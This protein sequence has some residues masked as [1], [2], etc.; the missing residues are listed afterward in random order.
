MLLKYGKRQCLT[1]IFLLRMEFSL[2][3]DTKE[4][5]KCPHKLRELTSDTPSA[6][7]AEHTGNWLSIVMPTVLSNYSPGTSP[8][9]AFPLLLVLALNSTET[10]IQNDATCETF[11]L[12][13][14]SHY[15]WLS[16]PVSMNRHTH[17]MAHPVSFPLSMFI[18]F[19][20]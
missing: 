4:A 5:A 11:P 3:E 2:T 19:P 20:L 8:H 15:P 6:L 13:K 1:I 14:P 7:P 16:V 12:S 18:R 17:V 9:C 10:I